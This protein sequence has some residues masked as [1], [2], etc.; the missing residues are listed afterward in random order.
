MWPSKSSGAAYG[1][2]PQNVARRPSSGN[3]VPNP[4]SETNGNDSEDGGMCDVSAATV[5]SGV[6]VVQVVDDE[7]QRIANANP[8]SQM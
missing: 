4:K 6:Q 2:E 1:G 5:N 8:S 7:Y 3:S